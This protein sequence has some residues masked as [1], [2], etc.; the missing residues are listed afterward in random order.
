[1]R[2]VLIAGVAATVVAGGG[3]AFALAS[4]H[5]KV[6]SHRPPGTATSEITRGDLVDTTSVEGTLTYA[7]E[8]M[9]PIGANGTVTWAPR[10]GASVSRGEALMK[11]DGR[12]VTLMYGSVPMYRTLHAGVSKG[13]D[14]RELERNLA[15]LGYGGL[16]VDDT[17]SSATAAAVKKW[18]KHHGLPETGKVDAGQVVFQPAAV[19]IKEVKV[20]VGGRTAPGQPALTVTATRRLVHVDLDADKQ[21]LAH[22]GATVTVG[23]PGGKTAKGRI[24]GVGSVARKSGGQGQESK[25]TVDVD[26]SL[27]GA[28]TGRLD[29]SPVT[30]ELE[31]SRRR[32]VL[33]VP[34][35]ALLALRE[36]GFGVEIVEGAGR[37]VVPVSTGGYGGGR[38]Q[39]S[40]PG[41]REGMKVGVPD[42]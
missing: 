8:R 1:M 21:N 42:S 38:V 15:A 16:T 10:P 17:F 34:I 39:I 36:G 7:D 9:V 33:S 30:V 28:G 40:G 12:P 25:A 4:G 37:R 18:Q 26:I 19:R 3:G 23:L 11:V 5:G 29:Q 2:R 31:S 14:V 27:D 20:A 6:A 32:N 41:L 22:R 35:E 13:K 24:S